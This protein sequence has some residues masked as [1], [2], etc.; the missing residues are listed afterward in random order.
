MNN[1]QIFNYNGNE[2][3]TIQ[4]DGEPWWVLK[5]VCGIL[6]ISK[7]RDTASRLD[8]DERGRLG[9]TPLGESRK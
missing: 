5:D 8:E 3:R 9:W 6:G 4:K 1:L 7:Y 2:V